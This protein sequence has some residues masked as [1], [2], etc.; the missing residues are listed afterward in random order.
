V[1]SGL[2]HVKKEV[3]MRCIRSSGALLAIFFVSACEYG[4]EHL[5]ALYHQRDTF[6]QRADE[7][8]ANIRA[9]ETQ[10]NLPAR[11]ESRNLQVRPG[12]SVAVGNA[13]VEAP[14]VNDSS[15]EDSGVQQQLGRMQDQLQFLEEKL[16]G[17]ENDL[18]RELSKQEQVAWLKHKDQIALERARMGLDTGSG[19]QRE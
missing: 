1:V 8:A 4:P 18:F 16:K 19:L 15:A 2:A 10:H 14:A 7:W 12:D 6:Q 3:T 13:A 5:D 11:G 17:F 9:I